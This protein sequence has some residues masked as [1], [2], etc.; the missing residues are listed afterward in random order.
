MN[1]THNTV[2]AIETIRR[3]NLAHLIALRNKRA[4]ENEAR[5]AACKA[6]AGLCA[7]LLADAQRRGRAE[8]DWVEYFRNADLNYP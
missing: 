3:A 8:I 7:L 1:T 5:R 6:N 2:S 4:S